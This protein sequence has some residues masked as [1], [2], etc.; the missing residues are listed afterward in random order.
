MPS[1]MEVYALLPKTNCKKCGET[2]CLSFAV[3]LL[4]R[5]KKLEECTPL[6]EDEKYKEQRN[7]L[8]ELLKPIME[9]AETGLLIHEERCFGC[10]NCVVAC[11]VNVANDPEGVALG[12]GPKSDKVILRVVNGVVKTFNLKSCRRFSEDKMLRV[13]DVCVR[14]CPNKAIEFA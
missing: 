3:K 4:S 10:N 8:L 6:F 11:P 1:P 13:C 2:T 12:Y 5:A 9:A 14:V 7:K